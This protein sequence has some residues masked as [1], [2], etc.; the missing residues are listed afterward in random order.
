MNTILP[1]VETG[2]ETLRP[3]GAAMNS[4]E[5]AGQ[6]SVAGS[7]VP[8]GKKVSRTDSNARGQTPSEAR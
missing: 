2:A 1:V 4:P 8:R 3:I 7:H 6:P 5:Y